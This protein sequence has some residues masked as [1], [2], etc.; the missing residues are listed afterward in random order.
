MVGPPDL[1]TSAGIAS[2]PGALPVDICF[3]ALHTSSSDGEISRLWFS[4]PHRKGCF[5]ELGAGGV[6]LGAVSGFLDRFH[7]T[8]IIINH[9]LDPVK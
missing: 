5:G 1:Y 3:M 6:S 9:H 2:E 8:I 7:Q 4:L